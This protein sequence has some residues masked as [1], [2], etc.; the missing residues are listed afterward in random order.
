[1]QDALYKLFMLRITGVNVAPACISV[2]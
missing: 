2:K 1:M